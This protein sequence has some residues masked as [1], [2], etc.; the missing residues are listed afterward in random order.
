[1]GLTTPPLAEFLVTFALAFTSA[2]VDTL[3]APTAIAAPALAH[4]FVLTA[5]ACVLG[6]LCGKAHPYFAKRPLLALAGTG[7]VITRLLDGLV[8]LQTTFI[9][10]SSAVMPARSPA[11]AR[12][13]Y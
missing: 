13:K 10:N 12:L 2:G 7:T 9:G 4:G 11:I 5:F 3:L 6:S 1:M 8:L